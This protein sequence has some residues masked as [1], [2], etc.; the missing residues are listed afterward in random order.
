MRLFV[1]VMSLRRE[2][3]I[4]SLPNNPTQNNQ[5]LSKRQHLLHLLNINLLP[6]PHEIPSHNQPERQECWCHSRSC[7]SHEFLQRF[8]DGAFIAEVIEETWSAA[9][10]Y[11]D[12][13]VADSRQTEKSVVSFER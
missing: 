8:R 11:V 2:S 5:P 3:L 4:L 9:G 7:T 13:L 1:P 12:N 10:G 6:H